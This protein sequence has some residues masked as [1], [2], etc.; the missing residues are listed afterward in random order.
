MEV[1]INIVGFGAA[2]AAH[3]QVDR[4]VFGLLGRLWRSRRRE[5][6]VVLRDVDVFLIAQR[7]LQL[8]GRICSLWCFGQERIDSFV[9]HLREVSLRLALN[10]F[11]VVAA[12]L[13]LLRRRRFLGKHH[14]QVGRF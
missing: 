2:R 10:V 11:V 6:L 4:I 12:A 7:A 13:L 14:R 8:V 1:S 9:L 3:A 5:D